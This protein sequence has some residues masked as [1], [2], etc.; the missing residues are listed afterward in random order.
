[1]R[2]VLTINAGSILTTRNDYYRVYWNGSQ[3]LR[4]NGDIIEA[5]Q[6]IMDNIKACFGDL[7]LDAE[8]R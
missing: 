3:L 4:C 5:P 2:W 8:L 1:M 6:N 7:P